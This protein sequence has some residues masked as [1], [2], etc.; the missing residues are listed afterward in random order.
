MD[1]R[2]DRRRRAE[3]HDGQHLERRIQGVAEAGDQVLHG[4]SPV[5]R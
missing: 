3:Q 1:T 5:W 4:H 2:R